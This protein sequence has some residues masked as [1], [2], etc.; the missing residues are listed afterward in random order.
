MNRFTT[1][2]LTKR[3]KFMNTDVEINKLSGLDVFAIQDLAKAAKA[4]NNDQDNLKIM[5]KVITCGVDEMKDM[6]EEEILSL[7]L[8]ELQNL[9]SEIMKFSGMGK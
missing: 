9:S 3:V 7:P 1:I 4:S 2:K 5:L 8:E 6:T